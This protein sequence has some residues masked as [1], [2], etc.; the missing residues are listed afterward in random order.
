MINNHML[1]IRVSREQLDKLKSIA[2]NKGYKT[3]SSYIRD[4]SLNRD[5]F[6][7][8]KILEIHNEVV[9]NGRIEHRS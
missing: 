5:L 8:K 4:V 6:L 3:L 7:E 2:L 1:R 9:K